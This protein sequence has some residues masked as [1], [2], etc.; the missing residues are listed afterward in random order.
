MKSIKILNFKYPLCAVVIF[1]FCLRLMAAP[2]GVLNNINGNVFLV[3]SGEFVSAKKGD[4]LSVNDEIIVELGSFAQFLDYKDRLIN[5]SGSTSLQL[6]LNTYTL[7][8]GMLWV[9]LNKK[10]ETVLLSGNT[11]VEL[12]EGEGV[13]SY[14]PS[15]SVT[16]YVSIDGL[17]RMSNLAQK[18][19]EVFV[20]PGSFSIINPAED[21]GRPRPQSEIGESSYKKI[22]T[23]FSFVRSK[24]APIEKSSFPLRKIKIKREIASLPKLKNQKTAEVESQKLQK[25]ALEENLRKYRKKKVVYKYPRVK[26]NYFVSAKEKLM[27]RRKPASEAKPKPSKFRQDLFKQYKNQRKYDASIRQLVNELESFKMDYFES[28]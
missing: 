6:G 11:R 28:Y 1:L 3:K 25:I 4:H 2:L 20:S 27:P 10:V 16:Q 18:E 26:V 23:L 15:D 12:E 21:L 13:F 22:K 9:Q 14:N 7:K 19:F 24:R 8:K 17:S 5:L